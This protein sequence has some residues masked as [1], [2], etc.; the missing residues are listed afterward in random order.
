MDEQEENQEQVQSS[1]IIGGENREQIPWEE[2]PWKMPEEVR[3]R[4]PFADQEE[5]AERIEKHINSLSGRSRA[6]DIDEIEHGYRGDAWLKTTCREL[7][8][9]GFQRAMLGNVQI[10]TIYLTKVTRGDEDPTFELQVF[11]YIPW[12]DKKIKFTLQELFSFERFQIKICGALHFLPFGEKNWIEDKRERVHTLYVGSKQD[13][14]HYPKGSNIKREWHRII[15]DKLNDNWGLTLRTCPKEM[16]QEGD[17]WERIIQW[18]ETVPSAYDVD[19]LKTHHAYHEDKASWFQPKVAREMLRRTYKEEISP[20]KLWDILREHGIKDGTVRIGSKTA[21]AW[22]IPIKLMKNP[23]R[24]ILWEDMKE[25]ETL[26]LSENH[27]ERDVMTSEDIAERDSRMGIPPKVITTFAE[28]KKSQSHV[29][30]DA[31]K[32]HNECEDFSEEADEIPF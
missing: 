19:E 7:A 5:I 11:D 29:Q 12:R 1:D 9:E 22:E 6:I 32:N 8:I 26:L 25:S 14:T 23:E 10:M 21:H 28:T 16:T 18:I 2:K 4:I 20:T 17:I 31:E 13:I 27:N 24:R 15:E 30:N 3:K